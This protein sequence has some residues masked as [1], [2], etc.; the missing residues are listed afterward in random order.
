MKKDASRQHGNLLKYIATIALFVCYM[1]ANA[2][3]VFFSPG[4]DCEDKIVG[5]IDN[6]K[7]EVVAAVYSLNNTRIVEALQKAFKRGI[8]VRV[9]TDRVQASNRASGVLTLWETGL[10]IRVNSVYKIE[11]NKFGVF[12]KTL[13]VTGSFNWTNAARHVNSENCLVLNEENAISAFHKRFEDLWGLNTEAKSLPYLKKLAAKS[14]PQK[15]PRTIA[16]EP[17]A[18]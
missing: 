18:K 7:K 5:A 1:R 13:A 17:T 15:T 8:S 4:P 14:S 12:D 6:S 2:V 9:L 11:H 3:E 16:S 10:P